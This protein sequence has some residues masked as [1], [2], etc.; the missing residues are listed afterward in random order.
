MTLNILVF[1][2]GWS[3]EREV[4]L[5]SSKAAAD[6]LQAL[7]HNV[8]WFDVPKDPTK[9]LAQITQTK[10]DIIFNGLHGRGGE[11]GTVQA[12]LDM[13]GVP[14]THSGVA[15]SAIAMDKL[16]T[17]RIL[18]HKNVPMVADSLVTRA[19]LQ[20]GQH[21][22]PKPYVIKPIT[23]GSSVG[24][25]IVRETDNQ[26]NVADGTPNEV[27]LAEAFVAGREFTVAVAD[28]CNTSHTPVALGVTELVSTREFYDYTA[29]YTDGQ[30]THLVNP[31]L[32]AEL[33]TQL[34]HYAVIAHMALGCRQVSRSDFRYDPTTNTLAFLE[35]NTQPGLTPLSL[36]PE[37][38]NAVG[39]DFG[40]LVMAMV[41][42]ALPPAQRTQYMPKLPESLTANFNIVSLTHAA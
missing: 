23:E 25:T 21:P 36:L 42:D 37:Q 39:I 4:S 24:V 20:A 9:I 19:Q 41:A 1:G 5:V 6:A 34:K 22:L 28:F 8:T 18:A 17:K 15:A 29:K 14:Y 13:V 12:L 2:G 3:A 27:L 10:P 32:P 38:A 40:T 33:T 7:G 11:D 16:Y 31:D 26:I 30:T 35:I